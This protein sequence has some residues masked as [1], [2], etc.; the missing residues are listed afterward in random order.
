MLVINQRVTLKAILFCPDWLGM[1]CSCRIFSEYARKKKHIQVLWTWPDDKRMITQAEM[2]TWKG[3]K[4]HPEAK[5]CVI[6]YAMINSINSTGSGMPVRCDRGVMWCFS[7][8]LLMRTQLEVF[9]QIWQLVYL[10]ISGNYK[11]QDSGKRERFLHLVL[12]ELVLTQCSPC[13]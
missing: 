7:I 4:R 9:L 6:F 8:L 3:F 2:F 13:L 1:T 10:C 11:S 5:S 12:R